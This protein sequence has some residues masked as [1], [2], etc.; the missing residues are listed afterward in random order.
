MA[1]PDPFPAEYKIP[2][3]DS[4]DVLFAGDPKFKEELK[5]LQK[6]VLEHVIQLFGE[7]ELAFK[8]G[9][10]SSRAIIL[11]GVPEMVSKQSLVKILS[12]DLTGSVP[13]VE[14]SL[15]MLRGH[16]PDH[17][18]IKEAIELVKVSIKKST[19]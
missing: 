4:N 6:S 17:V 13:F 7:A 1:S 18:C 3:V 14:Q 8:A 12:L 15:L 19:S 9:D 5:A 16:A 11:E 10:P 2:G